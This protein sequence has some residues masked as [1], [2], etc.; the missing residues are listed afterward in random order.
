M[1]GQTAALS[2]LASAL[3]TSSAEGAYFQIG[4]IDE[5][6]DRLQEGEAVQGRLQAIIESVLGWMVSAGLVDI[7]QA[8]SAGRRPFLHA[9]AAAAREE[10]ARSPASSNA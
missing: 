8:Y 7:A 2:D 10:S 3:P 4:L 5:L 6:L 9:M 1:W